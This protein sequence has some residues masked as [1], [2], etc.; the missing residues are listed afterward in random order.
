MSLL[1]LLR[2]GRPSAETVPRLRR[3]SA[4]A[5]TL[6]LDY[7]ES[8]NPQE[9]VPLTSFP[10]WIPTEHWELLP[11][12]NT[13]LLR[14]SGLDVHRVTETFDHGGHSFRLSNLGQPVSTLPSRPLARY[15]LVADYQR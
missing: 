12:G 14:G 8:Q 4:N 15:L 7:A 5:P 2:R 3:V 9:P 1:P 13:V 11:E 6:P 10:Q